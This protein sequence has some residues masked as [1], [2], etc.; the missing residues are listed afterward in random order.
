MRNIT[1]STP[2]LLFA[3]M[4]LAF[5]F[6][7]G[8]QA[9]SGQ[10]D[11]TP[12]PVMM[13]DEGGAQAHPAHVH[14]GTCET[15]GDVVH[16]LSDVAPLGPDAT[17]MGMAEASPAAKHGEHGSV[18]AESTTILDVAL[19]D[20]LGAEHAVNVHESAENI[21][22]Y[23]ACGDITGEP[24][25]GHLSVEL[26]ELNDSGYMGHAVFTSNDD[27]TTTVTVTLM[28]GDSDMTGTPEATPA[29]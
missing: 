22:N 24:E 17:P 23:I 27:G 11:A 7:F 9:A 18:V 8:A 20:I 10:G 6:V 3:A 12:S 29:A 21:Q 28:Q 4:V 14:S 1:F 15:L 2:T 5:S 13:D 26:Q 16:P 19:E 25:N